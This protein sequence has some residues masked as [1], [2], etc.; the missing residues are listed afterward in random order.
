MKFSSRLFINAAKIFPASYR[1]GFNQLEIYSG[2]KK[3]SDEIL[4]KSLVIG[5]ILAP[6]IFFIPIVFSVDNN[7]YYT[8][9]AFG[10]F[11][12]IQIITYLFVYFK[13]EERTK[14]VEAALPDVFQIVA[15]N[16]RAGMTPYKA[17]K[18]ST[19]KEFG[20]LA[21][22]I[23]KAISRGLGTESFSSILLRISENVKSDLVDR[24]LKLFTTAMRSGGNLATLLEDIAT[25]I[26]ET[27]AL[28]N[29]LKTSTK[30][31]TAFIMFTVIIGAP[32][33]LA[34]SV[35]F[36]KM[37]SSMQAQTVSQD[38]TFGMGFLM[39]V[40]EITP[41]FLIKISV[42]N[43]VITSILSSTLL[44]VINEGKAKSGL[45]YV[46]IIMISCIVVFFIAIN[47]V[48]NLLSG[49]T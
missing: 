2:H 18:Q 7:N 44:G 49:M 29:E 16:L 34:I 8:L 48:G 4:G 37:I 24:S 46:P 27:R 35:N 20:P 33:L 43:I 23:R 38:L 14:R 1:K 9:S 40:V 13:A 12:I 15:A 31:Y 6:I 19:R 30:T 32:L 21:E 17:L 25:D 39:G 45:R 28:K 22:E 3:N 10:I 5:F 47:V 26:S 41:D 42:I 11:I 36:V